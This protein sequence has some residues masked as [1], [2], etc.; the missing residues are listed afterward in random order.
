MRHCRVVSSSFS[1]PARAIPAQG[2]KKSSGGR[3]K[4]ERIR[5]VVPLADAALN[6]ARGPGRRE[7]GGGE[8]KG[9][10]DN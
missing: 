6:R 5:I 1:Y 8:E 7:R 4:R 3:K 10:G 2:W 9:N